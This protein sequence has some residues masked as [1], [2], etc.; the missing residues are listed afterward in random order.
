M[1]SLA[2]RVARPRL[3]VGP[4]RIGGF[5]GVEGLRAWLRRPPDRGGRRRDPPVRRGDVGQRRR[6]VRGRR[7]CRCCG[8]RDPAGRTPRAPTTGTG[9]TTTTRPR[10]SRPTLGRATVPHGRSPVARPVRRAARR[11]SGRRPGRRP[12]RD[13][14]ALA[15]D[16][17]PATAAPTTSPASVELIARA[18]HRR[19]RHQGLRRQLHLAQDA[20]RRAARRARGRRTTIRCERRRRDRRRRGVGGAVDRPRSAEAERTIVEACRPRVSPPPRP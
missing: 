1:S 6:G 17:A 9:S 4:V 11:A 16:G 14:A 3:P 8:S 13:R 20:G 19:A 12:A 18:R 5:G 15:V 7:T 10:R 2:G